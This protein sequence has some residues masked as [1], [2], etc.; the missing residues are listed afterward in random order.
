MGRLI[1]FLLGGA[2]I[3]FF[4]A[5]LLPAGE[6]RTGLLELWEPHIE[7]WLGEEQRKLLV[8]SLAGLIGGVSLLLFATRGGGGGD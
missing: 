3:A 8:P 7:Q 2:A 4:G 1:A 5:Y 6:L